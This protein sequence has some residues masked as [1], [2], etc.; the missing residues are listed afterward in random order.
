VYADVYP[1]YMPPA[2]YP[3]RA[4]QYYQSGADG[5]CFWDTYCRIPR[6]AEWSAIRRLGHVDELVDL[7]ERAGS[8]RTVTPMLRAAGMSL[9]PP[10]TPAT[11]GWEAYQSEVG[12][13]AQAGDLRGVQVATWALLVRFAE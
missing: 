8:F 1:R 2:E 13:S 3:A 4:L 9:A 12:L 11:N 5:L 10:Y 6:A 7:R